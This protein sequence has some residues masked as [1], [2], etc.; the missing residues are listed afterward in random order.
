MTPDRWK[1]IDALLDLALEQEP[2]RRAAFLVQACAGDESLR[3]EVEA[4]L[5]A[6]EQAGSFLGSP[7]T[8]AA[9]K[10]VEDIPAPSLA[11]QTIG[12][13][14]VLSLIGKGGMGEVYLAQDSRLG[15]K[16]ALK[17]LPSQ[18]TQDRD[19]LRRFEREARAASALNH[20]NILT[21]YEIGEQSGSIFIATEFIEGQTLRQ[22]MAGGQLRLTEALDVAVQ[23]ASALGTAHAAGIVHRDIKP[24]NIMLRRDGFMKVLD[25][26]LAKLNERQVAIGQAKDA[27]A[28]WSETETGAVMGTTRYLSPEQARGLKV[29]GRTDIFSLGVVIYEMLAGR[30]PFE[31]DTATD[32]IIA[33]VEKEPLPLSQLAQVPA[34]LEK[35]VSKALSKNVETRYQTAGE[36]ESDVKRLRRRVEIDIEAGRLDSGTLELRR[37]TDAGRI[38]VEVPKPKSHISVL[39][40]MA[41]VLVTMIAAVAFWLVQSRNE[42]TGTPLVPVPLMTYP[43]FVLDPSFSPDGN[44]I[45]FSWDGE[46]RDNLNIYIKQIGS[47]SLRRLTT[48]KHGEASVAWSPDGLYI[49]FLRY[50]DRPKRAVMMIPANGG[51]ERQVAEVQTKG[52][53]FEGRILCWHPGGKWLAASSAP[54]DTPYA[55][56]L[57]SPETGEQRRLTSPPK[58]SWG[59]QYPA[60]SPDGQT[61]VFTRRVG[62]GSELY[63]LRVTA[64]LVA[65]GDPK[66]L[67]FSNKVSVNPTWTPDGK[68]IIFASGSVDHHCA[69]WRVSASG[70]GRPKPLPFSSEGAGRPTMSRQHNRLVYTAG[71]RSEINI[72][73]FRIP[74]GRGKPVPPSNFMASTRGQEGAQYSPDGKAVAYLA[75]TFGSAEIWVCDQDGKN[76]LQLTHLGGPSPNVFRWSPD[77]QNIVFSTASAGQLDIFKVPAQ[78]G[79][80]RQLTHTPS[81]EANPGYSR[82][83]KWLYFDSDRNGDSQIWKM[84][85]EGGEQ[86][87]VT[88]QSGSNAQESMDGKTLFYVKSKERPHYP[89][90]GELWKM[91]VEGGE[92]NRIIEE[93]MDA[94]FDV[95]QRGIYYAYAAES[96]SPRQ[97]LFYDFATGNTK[98]LTTIN[99]PVW[100]GFSVS[101]DEKWILYTQEQGE[102]INDLMLVENFR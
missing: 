83:G 3:R 20:P 82:D 89:G 51:R 91:P 32:V 45:A 14:Q 4:L 28:Y 30:P 2:S 23:V 60:F 49:A 27:K 73:Q 88:R 26:G 85:A 41:T 97:F 56:Y 31:G 93:V 22:L 47:E 16:I 54:N 69:L 78:G 37:E 29:D 7:L 48:D 18:F 90:D 81:N 5:A 42:N 99:D 46:K 58:G 94:N 84:P 40:G 63:L 43:G 36:L 11:G 64:E 95:K 76:P 1:Q 9:A 102:G 100:D 53:A 66:Q 77:G 44:Q 92:E 15:R 8:E 57:I 50:L 96:L 17:L 79:Q 70:S 13:Y 55:I 34:E 38:N 25:F 72:W 71:G 52:G 35:I 68:E 80:I 19:R 21:I 24:E 6:H 65:E 87:Q 59:D 39:L 86:F 10:A 101:P 33:I 62:G 67:T 98:H 74:S 12:P 75:Y 61:L